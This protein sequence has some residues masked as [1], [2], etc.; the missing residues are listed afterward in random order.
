MRRFFP[1]RRCAD[2]RERLNFLFLN[3][4][5][6]FDHFFGLVIA[7]VGLALGPQWGLAYDELIPYATPCFVMFG[8][9]AIPSGW[10]ADKW[11]REGM[12]LVR[13]E[14]RRVGKECVSTCRS[15]WSPYH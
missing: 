3:L 6:F 10:L 11:S 2:L 5:H 12:M 4:W 7:T 13:S 15:R 1:T 14:E 8:L 9:G